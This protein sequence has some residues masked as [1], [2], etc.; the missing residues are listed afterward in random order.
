MSLE[1]LSIREMENHADDIYESVVVMSKRAKQV[2]SDRIVE[3]IIDST[4]EDE[5]GVYDEVI[6]TNPDDYEELE[7]PTSVS[8][9]EFLDGTIE[10]KK[11]QEES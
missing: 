7:K 9:N 3:D 2:L 1:P 8:V 4:E 6:E 5:M 11:D 10:W